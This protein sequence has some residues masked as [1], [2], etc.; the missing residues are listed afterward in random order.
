MKDGRPQV[1]SSSANR[2]LAVA[3][4]S[5]VDCLKRA[6]CLV[7]LLASLPSAAGGEALTGYEALREW[8]SLPLGKTGDCMT[9]MS[10]KRVRHLPV[11]EEGKLLGLVSTGDLMAMQVDEKQAVIDDLYLYLHGRHR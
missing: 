1:S 6:A 3:V 4:F 2:S 7:V 11:V 8:A 5:R 9:V 10:L